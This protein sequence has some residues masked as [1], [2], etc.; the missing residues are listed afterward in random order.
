MSAEAAELDV[1]AIDPRPCGLC[2]LTLDRHRVVDQG[3]GPEH[4][5][6]DILIDDLTLDE[7]ERRT[8][9]RREEEIARIVAEM[10]A[11]DDPSMRQPP[12]AQPAPY[13][14]PQA[15]QDA[16]WYVVGLKDPERLSAWLRD[17]PRDTP[18]LL[19]LLEAQ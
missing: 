5:C 17:H 4:L 8:E 1:I 15:T 13:R 12:P 3:E 14:T 16:F 6:P 11:L 10:E 2:G 19:T 9:L 18:F 7:L